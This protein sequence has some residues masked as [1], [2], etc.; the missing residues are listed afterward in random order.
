MSIYFVRLLCIQMSKISLFFPPLKHLFALSCLFFSHV[1]CAQNTTEAP[2]PETWGDQFVT[3]IQSASAS[4]Q[5]A[6]VLRI[7]S[8]AALANP[9][10]ERLL[11]LVGKLQNEFNPLEYHHSDL[12]AMELSP[13]NISRVLHIY[14][15]KKDAPMWRDIQMRLDP[16]PPHKLLSI[17][18]IAEVA[19]PVS[20]PNG[21]ITQKT[22]LDWLDRYVQKLVRENDLSGSALVAQGDQILFEK[23][24][25]Y[26]D[27]E[28]IQPV[29]AHTLF[30][31]GSGNKMFTA[32]AVMR[33]Q[34]QGKLNFTDKLTSWFPDF[35][36]SAHANK[37]TVHHLLTHTSGIREF[38]REET[39]AEMRRCTTWHQFLP[40]IYGSGFDFKPG[41][42]AGYSNSNFILLGAI[43]EKVSGQDYFDFIQ[44]LIYDKAGMQQSGTFVF[45]RTTKPLA[46]PL[47]RAGN[48]GWK[49]A[50][51]G[52]RGSPTGGGYSNVRDM[53]LFAKKLKNNSFVSSES[54]KNMISDKTSGLK[55]AFP[56]G[57]GFIPQKN[58]GEYSYGHGG[59]ASGINLEF[60]YFPRLDI[61]M[62]VF[63]NQD[64][65]AFDDLKKNIVKLITGER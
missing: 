41:T 36:D 50:E 62:I 37:V 42:E 58:G 5:E 45:D 61:T 59:I 2:S 38:W 11:S 3:A 14:L 54:F 1:A 13:G 56:Y 48:E 20:L 49:E 17:A 28:R 21:D 7:F 33:L 63:S 30:N 10:K 35:P 24:F 25:G 22:T 40:I 26:A 34:E 8:D 53:L 19:E 39:V 29:D 15:R 6:I 46:T 32:L 12:M 9:G 44:N 18:F 52:K 64:N 55:N 16:A 51:H 57:Y 43:I 60:R 65:G 23:Y 4:E 31:L 27:A 47:A